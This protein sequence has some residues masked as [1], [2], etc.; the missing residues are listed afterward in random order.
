MNRMN[1]LIPCR[2]GQTRPLIWTSN[3]LP[4]EGNICHP[5]R[6]S[7]GNSNP[8]FN[9]LPICS[10]GEDSD[11]EEEL[12]SK[13]KKRKTSQ[14]S[15]SKNLDSAERFHLKPSSSSGSGYRGSNSSSN[16]SS[17]SLRC[18]NPPSRGSSL[19]SSPRGS[20]SSLP[21]ESTVSSNR[22]NEDFSSPPFSSVKVKSEPRIF[23]LSHIPL[24]SS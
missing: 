24:I 3:T 9:Y 6:I 5:S 10:E 16:T 1:L 2:V 14:L 19:S 8:R 15:N 23:V 7:C 21:H 13:R 12:N 20:S 11:G 18:P 17:S 4:K 22:D